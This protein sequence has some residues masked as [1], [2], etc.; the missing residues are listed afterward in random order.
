MPGDNTRSS[1]DGSGWQ[2]RLQRLTK[3]IVEPE[4]AQGG[5]LQGKGVV[6]EQGERRQ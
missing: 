3:Y 6:A 4:A 5:H 2:W 1:S